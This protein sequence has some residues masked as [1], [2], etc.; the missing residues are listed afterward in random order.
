MRKKILGSAVVVAC[1]VATCANAQQWYNQNLSY[2][3][4]NPYV[5]AY[6]A[7]FTANGKAYYGWGENSNGQLSPELYVYDPLTNGSTN[8]N[9][10]WGNRSHL[11]AFAIS[12]HGY[13]GLGNLESFGGPAYVSGIYQ[14]FDLTTEQLVGIVEFPGGPRLDAVTFTLGNKAYVGGGVDVDTTLGTSTNSND[15]WEY[16]PISDTWTARA[17]MPAA[18]AKGMS[19]TLNGKGYVMAEGSTALW[20]YDPIAN[21]WTPRAPYPGSPYVGRI[22]FALNGLGY[23]G[24]GTAAGTDYQNFYSYDPVANAWSTAPAMW[25]ASGRHSSLTF[26]LGNDAYVLGGKRGFSTI[27]SDLWRLGTPTNPAPGSW[28]QRP[29]MP[30]AGREHPIAFSIGNKGYIGGGKNGTIYYTDLWEY[31]PAT[32]TWTPK[33]AIPAN[34]D[35]AFSLGNMGY[36][37]TTSATQNFFAYD[38]VANAWSPRADL[39]GG[40]RSSAACFAMEGLGYVCTGLIGGIRQSDLWAYNPGTDTWTQRAN[41]PSA[42]HGAAAFAIGNKGYCVTGNEFGSSTMSDYMREYDPVTNTWSGIVALWARRQNAQAFAIGNTAYTSGGIMGGPTYVNTFYQYD[43][44]PETWSQGPTSGGGYRFNG[45]GFS[46]GNKG[47]VFG[48]RRNPDSGFLSGFYLSNDLWEYNPSIVSVAPRVFLEGCFVQGT[49]MMHDSL[50]LAGL[51]NTLDPYGAN[52]YVH[53][54][55]NYS[56]LPVQLP[57]TTGN[58]AVVDRVIV[59]V[60]EAAAPY[61]VRASRSLWLQRDGDVVDMDGTSVPRFTLPAGNYQLTVRHRNHLGAMTSTALAL[62]T[63]TSTVDFT[64]TG[65]STFGTNARKPIGGSMV[66]WAGDATFNGQLKYTGAQNDR[67]PILVRIG[68]LN[69]LNTVAG[70]YPEDVNMNGIVKYV[71]ANNDRDPILLNLGGVPLGVLNAQVP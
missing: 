13:F 19:F 24:C 40:A 12:N 38:P 71:G 47:Y 7:A 3:P 1:T 41:S 51:L 14:K 16:E 67:D 28:T 30:A 8:V 49:G 17:N 42:V 54:G 66:L 6:G 55:G 70:Y 59:E 21:T 43:P 10:A 35:V 56:D 2:Y 57:T 39:P 33:A 62:S 4:S 69:P 44:V 29:F 23:V 36:V 26:T 15:L 52:G 64:L 27:L 61:A 45:V 20:E 46:I 9:N 60:K 5:R 31:D 34:T 53:P 32:M 58:N 22:A 68:G 25:D 50:R 37:T 63:T 65:T 11:S 48:G 18:I